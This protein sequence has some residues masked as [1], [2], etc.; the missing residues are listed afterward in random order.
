MTIEKKWTVYADYSCGLWDSE[1][2]G[3]GPD[4]EEINAPPEYVQ[5]FENWVAKYDMEDTPDLENFN[6]E[7]RALAV[8]LKKIVGPSYKVFFIGEGL[9]EEEISDENNP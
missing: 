3:S 1:G 4:D 7:G 6:K 9:G 5:R 2:V 8:E